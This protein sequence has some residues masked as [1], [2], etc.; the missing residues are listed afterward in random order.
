[1][2]IIRKSTIIEKNV[3]LNVDDFIMSLDIDMKS[4]IRSLQQTFKDRIVEV[5]ERVN[6]GILLLLMVI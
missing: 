2:Y 6:A 4:P 3:L 1:M 5:S